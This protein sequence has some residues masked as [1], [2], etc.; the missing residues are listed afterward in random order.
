MKRI[1]WTTAPRDC[2]GPEAIEL[3]TL[4]IFLGKPLRKVAIDAPAYQEQTERYASGTF[5]LWERT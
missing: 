3:E 4:G 5:D 1:V 2:D